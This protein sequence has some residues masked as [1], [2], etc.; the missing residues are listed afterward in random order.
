[1]VSPYYRQVYNIR[2]TLVGNKI[3]DHSDV[4]EASPVGATPTTIFILNLTAPL[5]R[6]SVHWLVQ[7]TLQ[8]HWSVTGW[9][10]V[11]WDTTGP[12]SEYLQ[13][14]LEHHW[15]NVHVVETALHWNAT[16]ET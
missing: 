8:C 15:K 2:R 7:C 1:M 5:P 14:T 12:P 10:S 16:G 4:V 11:H 3:D 6:A 13:A 9:P